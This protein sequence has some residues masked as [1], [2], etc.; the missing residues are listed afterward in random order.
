M[1]SFAAYFTVSGFETN[2]NYV[3]LDINQAVD[4]LGRPASL[5]RG[6]KVT[7]EFN[8]TDDTVVTEW[9]VNPAKRMDCKVTFLG[10]LRETLKTME[11]T[12]AYCVEMHERFD[13][14][15]S[16]SQMVTTI[17]I[18]P[19]KIKVGGIELN[20]RWPETE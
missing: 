13:G 20:N 18:S 7:L 3:Y 5:T 1:A 12:N 17:T 6:G 14:T 9:M 4:T 8:S 10:L 19:E 11:L 2:L 16:S 15:T